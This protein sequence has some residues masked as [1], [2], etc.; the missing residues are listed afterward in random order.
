MMN[1]GAFSLE[2]VSVALAGLLAWL[3]PR[4]LPWRYPP[5]QRKAAAN[6]VFEA[7]WI[8]LLAARLKYVWHWWP[9]YVDTPRSILAIGDG[10]FHWRAGLLI[11]LACV[12]W[13]T[14]GA[15][16]L[17]RPVLGGI[18]V[19]MMAWGLAQGPLLL[20]NRA[21]PTLPNLALST[22]DAKPVT[23]KGYIGQPLVVNLWATWCPPCQ[24]EMPMLERAQHDYPEVTFLM[25]NQGED[26]QAVGSFLGWERLR[27]RHV[28][29]DPF[30]RTGQ[31]LGARGLPTTL[32]FD[33]GGQLVQSHMGELTA[34]RLRD[35]AQQHFTH[36]S[37][38]NTAQD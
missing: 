24:R 34:A 6:L 20:M 28:L 12:W 38:V 1:V 7:F 37:A 35:I 29:L 15:H 23:L 8:G 21:P 17:R 27:F 31:E 2:A 11:A 4:F 32:F 25:I 22:L 36:R 26:A 16:G 30:S 13:R 9:D 5:D 18:A 3:V 19:G 10:G 33:A 14:R